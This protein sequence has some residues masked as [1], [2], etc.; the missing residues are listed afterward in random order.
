[1][2]SLVFPLDE[3]PRLR[4]VEIIPIQ[5]ERRRGLVLRDPADL[6]IP[7]IVV[8]DG[9]IEILA[10]LDGERTVEAVFAALQLG[11]FGATADQ[12]R[13]FLEQLDAAGY[14]EGARARYRLQQRVEQFRSQTVRVARH[15][16]GAYPDSI[17]ELPRMLAAG[18]L[19]ADG[20]GALPGTRANTKPPLHAL[21]APHVDLHRGAPTYSWAYKALAEAQPA[22]LYVILGTCHTRVLGGFAAT[23]K[24]YDTPLGAVPS[25]AAFIER[26]GQLWGQDLIAGEFSHA[27]EHSIEFQTVYL[28]SLGL[29]GEGTAPIVPIL[30]DSL[31]TLVP[32][33]RPPREAARVA[34]F[35][36][37][38]QQA[39]AED[40]RSTTVIA[41]VD[42]AHIGP[43]F[44]DPW[45]VDPS[46][47]DS[48]AQ[49]DRELLAQ[50]LEPNADAYFE[51]V[52]RD[53][54]ARRICGFTPLYLVAALMESQQRAGSL[55]RYTQWAAPD[56]SSSVTFASAVYSSQ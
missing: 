48:V 1:M 20:P 56:G 4:P 47:L 18:Y 8:S 15:A 54:D 43:R 17:D 51:H 36:G 28:R 16:G 13:R 19:H 7:P 14:L 46:R 52:M 45:L 9:A 50:V 32:P 22:E 12:V 34:D 29:A 10:L 37:A 27:A 49:A 26:L 5:D 3:R 30:C 38:L 25:D 33:G 41:A 55:L 42:L 23:D 44:G 31:H 35:L 24:A 39:L 2:V 6:E 21:I 53:G 11:G 40:G